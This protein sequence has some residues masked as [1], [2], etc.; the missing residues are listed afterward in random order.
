MIRFELFDLCEK[1][2]PTIITVN[3]NCQISKIQNFLIDRQSKVFNW[4]TPKLG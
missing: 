3:V 4:T 1:I 2:R